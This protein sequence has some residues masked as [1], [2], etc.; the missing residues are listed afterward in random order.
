M[1]TLVIHPKDKTTDFLSEIYHGQDWLIV[2]DNV[3]KSVLKKLINEHD[4]IIMLGHGDEKGLYGFG[5]HVIDSKLVYLLRKKD[6]VC[7]WCNADMFV[8]KYELKG[9]YTG[10][11]I[12]D[13]DEAYYCAIQATHSQVNESNILFAS[14]LKKYIHGADVLNEYNSTINPVIQF[15]SEKI[16]LK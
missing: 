2:C 11:I 4:R 13:I 10:M 15:N 6:L 8:Y 5:H 12:S 16:Y 9:L 3:S 14:T 7:I 1:K